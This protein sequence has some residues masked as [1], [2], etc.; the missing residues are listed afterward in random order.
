MTNQGLPVKKYLIGIAVHPLS[1]KSTTFTVPMES[2]EIYDQVNNRYGSIV[3]SN[4]GRYEQTVAKAFGYSEQDL[5]SIPEGAN[6]GLS[7]GNPTA[8]A[9][10]REVCIFTRDGVLFR[11]M[12]KRAKQ[13]S[14]LGLALA[15]MCLQQR[16]R[17]ALRV[18]L[19]E[20]T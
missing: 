4:T 9:R 11:L 20:L 15:S 17:L 18:G 2:K 3:K 5:A 19:L 16:R 6:L 14:I 1:S 8:I 13:S 10:L 7:C 12:G